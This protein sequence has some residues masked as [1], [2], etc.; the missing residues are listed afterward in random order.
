MGFATRKAAL[1]WERS[2]LDQGAKSPDILFSSLVKNYMEDNETRLKP[3]TLENKQS[4]FDDKITPYFGNVKISN[5]DAVMIRK[6]QNELLSYRSKDGE[7]YAPTYLKTI[8]AQ[9]S[10]ITNYAVKY[11]GLPS[12]P[13]HVSGSIGKSNAG[14][15]SIWTR[16]QFE[17]FITFEKHYSFHCAFNT[18]FYTGMREGELLALTPQDILVDEKSISINKNYAVVKGDEYFLTP[19]TDKSKRIITIHKQLCDELQAYI[20][21]MCINPDE[22]IF[23]FTKSGL[24]KEF[25]RVTDRAELPHIRI[26]DLR[27]SHASM[28]IQMK[29]PITEI[30][31]RLGHESP[32]ITLRIYSHLYPGNE[33]NVPNLI[34]AL[35]E[36]ESM[37]NMDDSE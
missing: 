11:Y 3:T 24:S 4:I 29:V 6:W 15:M 20:S 26:H 16:E 18:L 5:I 13:C 27:H 30:S 31:K 35:F 33:R 19:K 2:F 36:P 12:N 25:A 14:E 22:R 7:P 10:A 28:L 21:S 23:Y 8:H 32:E 1:E 34:D 17:Y 9:L 37:E